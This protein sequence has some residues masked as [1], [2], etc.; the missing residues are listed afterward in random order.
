MVLFRKHLP[1]FPHWLRQR[2]IMLSLDRP[3]PHF[4]GS[5]GLGLDL[6]GAGLCQNVANTLVVLV[7]SALVVPLF[8]LFSIGKRHCRHRQVPA[9]T[10]PGG[11]AGAS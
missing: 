4:D 10:R 5:V 9:A 8:S 1:P 7:P 3:T 2:H 11:R 6:P